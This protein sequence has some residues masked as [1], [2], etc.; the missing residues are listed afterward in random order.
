MR[1]VLIVKRLA[2]CCV[3]L[4]PFL[5]Y[6]QPKPT[7]QFSGQTFVQTYDL[8]LRE[9]TI[10]STK[11]FY[12]EFDAGHLPEAALKAMSSYELVPFV[13]VKSIYIGLPAGATLTVS[14]KRLA[15]ETKQNI[16]LA[17]V[18]SD[19]TLL[20]ESNITQRLKNSAAYARQTFCRHR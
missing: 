13:P 4:F 1:I 5:L 7:E 3:A 10:G 16:R 6:A 8:R 2:L 11:L 12:A 20:Q 14:A 18:A 9:E 19:N 17:P 15:G